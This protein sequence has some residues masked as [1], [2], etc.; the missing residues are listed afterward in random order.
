MP[1]S[2]IG[3]KYGIGRLYEIIQIFLFIHY[4]NHIVIPSTNH[5]NFSFMDYVIDKGI[6]ELWNMPCIKQHRK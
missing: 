3:I 5:N 1:E 6:W 4:H 2:L